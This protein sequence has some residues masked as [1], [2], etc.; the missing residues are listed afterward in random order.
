MQISIRNL[1]GRGPSRTPLPQGYERRAARTSFPTRSNAI[2]MRRPVI[3][4]AVPHSRRA[5]TAVE[6][7]KSKRFGIVPLPLAKLRHGFH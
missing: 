6:C 7:R 2:R 1:V 5:S 4:L 3:H